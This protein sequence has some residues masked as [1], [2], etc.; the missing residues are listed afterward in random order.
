MPTPENFT[1]LLGAGASANSLPVIRNFIERLEEYTS[2]IEKA[3]IDPNLCYSNINSSQSKEEFEKIR[4]QFLE[5]LRWF[6]SE[7]SNH[8]SVDTFAKRLFLTDNY[9]N[10]S[11]AKFI[12]SEFIFHE[13]IS[14]GT[15]RRYDTF[16]ASIL[17]LDEQNN[18]VL[19]NNIKLLSWNYDKQIEFSYGKFAQRK[20]SR[21]V[22]DELQVI[23]R[24][25]NVEENSVVTNKFSLLKI[26][27]S[28]GG[29]ISQ[30]GEYL[31]MLL[32]FGF[33]KSQFNKS[34][35]EIYSNIISRYFDH[36]ERISLIDYY[37]NIHEVDL[38]PTIFYSW[39]NIEIFNNVRT[40][41]MKV[42]EQT[43][44]LIVIG[45]SFPT[46]NR[47]LDKDVL[48]KMQNLKKIYVQDSNPQAVIQRLRAMLLKDV[49]IE[50]IENIDEFYIPFEFD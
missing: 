47:K 6:H 17:S 5:D 35:K 11:L 48:N 42:A 30:T 41:A 46:F 8:S 4:A 32:D 26:N 10:L 14:H 18:I 36:K 7:C 2:K 20:K 37:K 28:V 22:E 25:G 39:D 9:F 27:G 43:N 49:K 50:P 21:Y 45:Y 23:P 16:F 19:P 15:D 31:P 1:Y 13:E 44:Y 12:I 24:L 29:T 3:E 40:Q 34:Q 38:F 33:T